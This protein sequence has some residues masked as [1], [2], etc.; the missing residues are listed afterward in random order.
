VTLWGDGSPTRDFLH[1]SDAARA[2]RLALARYDDAE[3]VNVS[4][5]SEVSI[6]SLAD[7]IA[8]L[9]GY[10]GVIHWDR[11]F[12]NGQARRRL[13]PSRARQVFGFSATTT[14]EAG[15]RDLVEWFERHGA[16]G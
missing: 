4:S 13:D 7:I 11:S 12:P 10:S 14:L 6:R 15:L 5:G 2:C 1:V 3:P 16:S 8:G 9:I